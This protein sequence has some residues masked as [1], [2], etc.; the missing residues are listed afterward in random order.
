MPEGTDLAA[1]FYYSFKSISNLIRLF[2]IPCLHKKGL[3]PHSG[4]I[5]ER[6]IL[7][8]EIAFEAT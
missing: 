8:N 2:K 5:A 4:K 3:C 7:Y 1:G 6:S